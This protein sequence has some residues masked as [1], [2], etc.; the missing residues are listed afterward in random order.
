[1]LHVKVQEA[2]ICIG[3]IMAGMLYEPKGRIEYISHDHL[4]D[5]WD[6]SHDQTYLVY[7]STFTYTWYYSTTYDTTGRTFAVIMWKHYVKRLPLADNLW[8][9]SGYYYGN[10]PKFI[11]RRLYL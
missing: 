3:L 4:L 7:E 5:I 11:Y 8:H 2:T 9:L 1:M 6:R 10:I